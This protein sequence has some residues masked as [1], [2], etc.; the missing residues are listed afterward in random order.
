MLQSSSSTACS[1]PLRESQAKA[2]QLINSQEAMR[3]CPTAAPCADRE[4]SGKRASHV[5]MPE[6]SQ[7]FCQDLDQLPTSLACVVSGETFKVVGV[8]WQSQFPTLLSCL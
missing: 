7:G 1:F 5:L 4:A 3:N 6:G 8:P 2:S